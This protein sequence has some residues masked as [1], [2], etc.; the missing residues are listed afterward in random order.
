MVGRTLLGERVWDVKRAVEVLKTEFGLADLPF[1]CMGNSG[2]GT[3]T[4]Y[5]AALLPELAG[6][7]PSC[8]VCTW[9]HSIAMRQHCECNYVPHIAE[10]FDMGEIAALIA[11]RPYVQVNG[12]DDP[13]FLQVGAEDAFREA[14]RVYA[15]AGASENCRLVIGEGGHRF[16]ARAAWKAFGEILGQTPEE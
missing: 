7:I 8:S 2:G 16:Y 9:E 14:A 4:V 11:P 3:A 6:A 12:R 10:Y 15:A 13:I 5:A 1:Y